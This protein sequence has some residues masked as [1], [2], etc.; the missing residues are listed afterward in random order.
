MSFKGPTQDDQNSDLEGVYFIGKVV[1][2]DDPLK[3]ERIKVS[4]P[5]IFEGDHV[6]FPWCGP[7]K[8][9]WFPNTSSF[10]V[11]GLIPP[12]GTEVKVL[13]QR[14]N[15]L[16]PLYF[17]YPHQKEERPAE[18]ITN[19]LKRY[20]FKDPQGNLFFIDTTP[21]ANP[22]V[23]FAHVTG[24]TIIITDTGNL[25]V[26]V[27][28]GDV[29]LSVP[30]GDVNVDVSAGVNIE[31]GNNVNVN[32]CDVLVTSG[33]VVADGISLKGHHHTEQGDGMPTS[34]AQA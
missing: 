16:Y 17:A 32:N 28:S 12:V 11:F 33:D 8:A 34:A 2:N 30:A 14:G 19:Y 13:F 21:G 7:S 6:N 24:V 22:Q 5:D 18:F 26:T 3:M 23:K 25:N 29:N 27:S 10:G 20:G 31:A 9:G 4:I 1:F 15:P